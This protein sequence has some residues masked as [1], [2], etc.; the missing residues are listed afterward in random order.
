MVLQPLMA[1]GH[2]PAISGLA[3][4]SRRWQSYR[5]QFVPSL[6]ANCRHTLPQHASVARRHCRA[7]QREAEPLQ[8]EEATGA[9]RH[10]EPIANFTQ[11]FSA[12]ALLEVSLVYVCSALLR[13][14]LGRRLCAPVCACLS[15][16][17]GQQRQ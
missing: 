10:P 2:Q 5:L 11:L 14:R 15:P 17:P 6:P 16:K 3:A 7:A 12:L 13:A 1:L 4:C 8:G 9:L